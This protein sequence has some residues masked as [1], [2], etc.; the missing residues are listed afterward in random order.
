[1]EGVADDLMFGAAEI[2]RDVFGK[3]NK[4]N[5]RKVYHLHHQGL[6]GTFKMGG[7]IAGRKSTIRERIAAHERS[8]NKT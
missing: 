3:D 6:L 8:S 5:R 1:M 7:E 4:K 2:A